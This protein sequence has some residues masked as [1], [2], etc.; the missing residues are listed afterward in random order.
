MVLIREVRPPFQACVCIIGQMSFASFG[1]RL[2]LKSLSHL[3]Q[4]LFL[5]F[6]YYHV[7]VDYFILLTELGLLGRALPD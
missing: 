3:F 6:S 2:V 1:E 7:I 5:F 4:G